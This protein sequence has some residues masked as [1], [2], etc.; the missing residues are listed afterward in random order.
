MKNLIRYNLV[1]FSAL[2]VYAVL[3]GFL[4]LSFN[5]LS[6]AAELSRSEARVIGK[7]IWLNECGGTVEGLTTWNVGENFGSFG[8]GHFIWF[9]KN[10]E[11]SF[12]ESFPKMLAYLHSRGAAVPAWVLTTPDCPWN[13]KEEFEA[14]RNSEQMKLL[15]A[16]LHSTLDLQADF[17]ALRLKEALPKMVAQLNPADQVHVEKQFQRLAKTPGG[18]YLLI[19]YVNFKGE[20]V[21]E[22]ERYQGVGWGLLQ[23]LLGMNGSATGEESLNE[24]ADSSIRV[25]TRRVELSPPARNE[26][27]WLKGWINRCHTYRDNILK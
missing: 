25:L 20:G 13:S 19:D 3:L 22:S 24:F 9:P 18:T 6:M 21:K 16:F 15:R 27:R 11:A 5:Q 4:F 12:E 23:V 26:A 17:A 2:R 1:L 7:K 14:Q 8:I 10:V